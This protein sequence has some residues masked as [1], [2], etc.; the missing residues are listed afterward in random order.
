VQRVRVSEISSYGLPVVLICRYPIVIQKAD[1]CTNV[2]F[3]EEFFSFFFFLSPPPGSIHTYSSKLIYGGPHLEI[4]LG[5]VLSVIYLFIYL[6]IRHVGM[7][8]GGYGP[9]ENIK[10]LERGRTNNPKVMPSKRQKGYTAKSKGN[11][12]H[13]TFPSTVGASREGSFGQLAM[14]ASDLA[15]R[16]VVGRSKVVVV[17]RRELSLRSLPKPSPAFPTGSPLESLSNWPNFRRLDF[18][19]V[20]RG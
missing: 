14:A 13:D 10:C 1:V 7:Q 5:G 19:P 16:R 4:I 15:R 3:W 11:S 17:V 2:F 6:I 9:L 8:L 12:L 18:V 20:S